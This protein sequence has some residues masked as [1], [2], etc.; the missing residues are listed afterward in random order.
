MVPG[1]ACWAHH[2]ARIT[3]DLLAQI[4]MA[5]THRDPGASSHAGAEGLMQFMPRTWREYGYGSP[6]NPGAATRAAC[7]YLDYLRQLFGGSLAKM[8]AAWNSGPNH[9]LRLIRRWGDDDWSYHL[10]HQTERFVNTVLSGLDS[11]CSP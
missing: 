4:A 2:V 3:H 9:V 7:I 5:E 10:P 1:G 8:L 11:K 6:F